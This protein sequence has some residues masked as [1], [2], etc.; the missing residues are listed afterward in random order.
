MRVENQLNGSHLYAS[1]DTRPVSFRLP[2]PGERDPY[3]GLSRTFYYEL[4][5]AGEIRFIR[6][7]KRGYARGVVLIPF[8]QVRSYL[9][10]NA[11]TGL[12]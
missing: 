4:E 3:F 10:R 7:K 11:S 6:L 8:D 2:K 9:Q 12:G 5:K 1:T